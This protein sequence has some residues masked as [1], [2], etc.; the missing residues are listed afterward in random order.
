VCNFSKDGQQQ[1]KFW[2]LNASWILKIKRWD[3][4]LPKN[5]RQKKIIY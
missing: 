1:Q 5:W 3:N 4:G 2:Q